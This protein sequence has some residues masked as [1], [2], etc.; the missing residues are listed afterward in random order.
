M[1][2]YTT[3]IAALSAAN[4]FYYQLNETS[5]TSIVDSGPNVLNMTKSG[6]PTMGQTSLLPGDPTNTSFFQ[7]QDQ[8]AASRTDNV[9]LDRPNTPGTKLAWCMW[10][11]PSLLEIGATQVLWN[12]GGLG[13][14]SF[15]GTSIR[16]VI[17]DTLTSSRDIVAPGQVH[18]VFAAYDFTNL[19]HKIYLNGVQVASGTPSAAPTWANTTPLEIGGIT[20][21][22]TNGFQGSLQHAAMWYDRT[23]T[24]SEVQGLYQ[25]GMTS[26]AE[27]AGQGANVFPW[28]RQVLAANG[29]RTRA[30]LSNDSDTRI[31]IAQGATATIGGGHI[32]YPGDYIET[33]R[34]KGGSVYQGAYSAISAAPMGAKRLALVE[35]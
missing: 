28:S 3:A 14:L 27:V 16:S 8:P 24:L 34:Y 9:I 29:A 22:G 17:T 18:F 4:R 13:S 12:K 32:L 19:T 23:F 1:S 26:V 21:F 6:T 20:S 33:P 2:A 30:R 7:T 35:E 5:G 15:V 25:I 10:A 11:T 31:Y